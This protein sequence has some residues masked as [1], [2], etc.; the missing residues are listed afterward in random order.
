MVTSASPQPLPVWTGMAQT[1][2]SPTSPKPYMGRYG[3]VKKPGFIHFFAETKRRNTT[4]IHQPRQLPTKNRKH[5]DKNV[6]MSVYHSCVHADKTSVPAEY[7]HDGAEVGRIG[8]AR[9]CYAQYF[10]DVGNA[11]LIF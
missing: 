4:S 8:H 9:Y 1:E 5:S 6:V 7:A 11:A 2:Y 10:G 3:P